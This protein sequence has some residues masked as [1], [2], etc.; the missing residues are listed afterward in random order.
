MRGHKGFINSLVVLLLCYTQTE[1]YYCCAE[2][3]G[4]V[5]VCGAHVV[6][7]LDIITMWVTTSVWGTIWDSITVKGT[8]FW[9]YFLFII[10]R[11]LSI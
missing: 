7:H 8:I 11:T 4:A 1:Q 5:L 2:Q 10:F 3:C 9:P 6:Y